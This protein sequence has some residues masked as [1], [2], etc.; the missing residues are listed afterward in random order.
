[1]KIAIMI[2]VLTLTIGCDEKVY[3][4]TTSVAVAICDSTGSAG[5]NIKIPSVGRRGTIVLV[6]IV[7]K[8]TACP[9]EDYICKDSIGNMYLAAC[10]MGCYTKSPGTKVYIS[11]DV[12]DE[13]FP[14]KIVAPYLD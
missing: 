11:Y 8:C 1:M 7:T 3:Q 2:L 9:Y 14:W 4:E 6:S 5:K 13:M 12:A 10:N